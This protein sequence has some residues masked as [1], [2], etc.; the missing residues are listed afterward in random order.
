MNILQKSFILINQFFQI[1]LLQKLHDY[2]LTYNLIHKCLRLKYI[3]STLLENAKHFGK[4][5]TQIY[6]PISSV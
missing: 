5:I 4:V 3:F 1:V 6:T 2:S